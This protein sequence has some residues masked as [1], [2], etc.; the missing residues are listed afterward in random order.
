VAI[1]RRRRIGIITTPPFKRRSAM[2]RPSNDS[3]VSGVIWA[4]SAIIREIYGIV[5]TF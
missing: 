2:E 5:S 1:K 4:R 3:E